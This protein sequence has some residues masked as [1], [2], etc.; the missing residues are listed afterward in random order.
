MPKFKAWDLLNSEEE[1][2]KEYDMDESDEV[3]TEH[4]ERLHHEEPMD[5]HEVRVVGEDGVPVDF[6]VEVEYEPTFHA[7]L[8]V[9]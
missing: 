5:V 1:Y 9:T 2:A 3:A 8:K 6:I 7:R 4:A